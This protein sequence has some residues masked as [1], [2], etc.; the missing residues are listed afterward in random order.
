LIK[1]TVNEKGEKEMD[2]ISVSQALQIAGRAG[3]YGTQWEDGFVTTFKHE[4]LP[5]LTHLLSQTPEPLVQA[6]LHPTAD[7][8]ELYAYHLPNSTLSNLMDI[9]VQLSTVDDNLYFMCNIEDFK[10]LAEMIQHV[11][12]PLRARYVFCCAPINRKMPFVC[13]MFL[14]FSRQYSRNEPVTFDWLC[15]QC[16]WPFSLPRT[17]LDLVHLEAVFDV[18]DLYLWLSYRFMDLFPDAN[19]VRDVQKELDDIIQQGVFQIT[20]L[21]KNSES[22]VSSNTP[23]ED[24]F[25]ISQRKS[26]YYK[27]PRTYTGD[28]GLP[29]GRLTERLLAQG[30]LTPGML[31][32]LKREW[33]MSNKNEPDKKG[34]GSTPRRKKRK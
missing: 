6:G 1:P 13:S 24:S 8:I 3:R 33:D 12:L 22:A 5:T 11:P 4:D 18:M 29:R 20:K 9:F 14:K 26:T 30:L 27:E 21:L 32:E 23:D 7:Q 31:D 25:A 34:G 28:G 15:N 16:G 2:T 19:L 17:I 10:F